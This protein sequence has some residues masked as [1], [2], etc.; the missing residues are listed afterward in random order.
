MIVVDCVLKNTGWIFFDVLKQDIDGNGTSR[1]ILK[2]TQ[3]ANFPI[4]V[5]LRARRTRA[6]FSCEHLT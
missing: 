6:K 2:N 5:I 4:Q 1:A 3:I